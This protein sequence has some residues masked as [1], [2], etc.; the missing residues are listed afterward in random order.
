MAALLH[1]DNLRRHASSS[2]AIAA[3]D[4]KCARPVLRIEATRRAVKP[5]LLASWRIGPDGH[6]TCVWAMQRTGD[7]RPPP[8]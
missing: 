4:R 1:I 6:L 7:S 2:A 5:H 8:D 3:M